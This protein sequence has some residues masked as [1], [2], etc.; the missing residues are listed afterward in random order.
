M[1]AIE[2]KTI[3]QSFKGSITTIEKEDEFRYFIDLGESLQFTLQLDDHGNWKSNN[4]FID[5][6]MVSAAGDFIENMEDFADV[7]SELDT[8]R[9]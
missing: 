2:I 9:N 8:L 5:P 4:P 1:S 3:N 7:L 6:A